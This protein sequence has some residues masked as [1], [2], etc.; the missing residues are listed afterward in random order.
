MNAIIQ[1]I[2]T[3]FT[4]EERRLFEARAAR[5]GRRP[6]AHLKHLLFGKKASGSATGPNKKVFSNQSSVFSPPAKPRKPTP[7]RAPQITEN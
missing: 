1:H 2:E 7:S 3:E 4:A 6:G 5:A